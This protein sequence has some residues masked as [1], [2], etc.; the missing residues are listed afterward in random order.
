MAGPLIGG[1]LWALLGPVPLL[2]TRAL[3]A[4]AT[5]IYALRTARLARTADG[6]RAADSVGEERERRSVTPATSDSLYRWRS[7][8]RSSD[9]PV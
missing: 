4:A 9:G 3:L 6:T 7:P 8:P 5:E 1:V 2:A